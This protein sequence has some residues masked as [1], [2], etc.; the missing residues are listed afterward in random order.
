M[1][2]IE[3]FK[4]NSTYLAFIVLFICSIKIGWTQ[5]KIIYENPLLQQQIP[6]E[7]RVNFT[8]FGNIFDAPDPKLF[9]S[10]RNAKDPITRIMVLEKIADYH[11]YKGDTDSILFYGN[12]I[13]KTINM[14]KRNLKGLNKKLSTAYKI[15]TEGSILNGL[16]E[17]AIKYSLEGISA[18]ENI[19]DSTEINYHRSNL[20]RANYQKGDYLKAL[21]LYNDCLKSKVN[22]NF[23][24]LKLYRETAN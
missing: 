11:F 16:Y 6:P 17:N 1:A 23:L 18:A 15:M 24:L 8:A 5:D 4:R 2:K 13:L 9:S 10:L 7:D 19:P 22:P 20:A 21:E 3:K 12:L 14:H